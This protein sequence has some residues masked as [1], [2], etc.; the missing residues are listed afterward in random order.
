MKHFSI[1]LYGFNNKGEVN[2]QVQRIGDLDNIP[3]VPD[4][5]FVLE[6]DLFLKKYCEPTIPGTSDL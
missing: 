3:E 1:T 4:K 5:E 6:L 2:L